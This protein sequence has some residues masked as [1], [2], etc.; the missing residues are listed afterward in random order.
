MCAT[1]GHQKDYLIGQL[2]RENPEPG[3]HRGGRP[4]NA[5]ITPQIFGWRKSH[6][7][8]FELVSGLRS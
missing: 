2:K 6:C 3:F 7:A 1:S 8:H 4:G 5:F